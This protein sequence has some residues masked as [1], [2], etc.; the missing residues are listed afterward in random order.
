[1]AILVPRWQDSSCQV[2]LQMC[3][4]FCTVEIAVCMGSPS[5]HHGPEYRGNIFSQKIIK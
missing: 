2:R 4:K 5:V 3:L 1:M